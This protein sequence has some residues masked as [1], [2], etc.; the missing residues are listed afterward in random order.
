M[1]S[2]LTPKVVLIDEVVHQVISQQYQFLQIVLCPHIIFGGD[3]QMHSHPERNDALGRIDRDIGT[4]ITFIGDDIR[5]DKL[6][7][8]CAKR[9]AGCVG[10]AR[11][12]DRLQSMDRPCDFMVRHDGLDQTLILLQPKQAAAQQ[13]LNL[14]LQRLQCAVCG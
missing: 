7:N 6:A 3:A 12:T 13:S 4:S 10:D 8:Q 1:A 14:M 2:V 11:S 9:F 5:S